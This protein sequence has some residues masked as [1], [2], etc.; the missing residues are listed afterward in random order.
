MMVCF[1]F[2]FFTENT[3]CSELENTLNSNLDQFLALLRD[4]RYD[5]YLSL[6]FL[7]LHS[8]ASLK[9]GRFLFRLK[10]AVKD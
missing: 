2:F 5:I 6:Q 4:A 7:Q 9:R 1:L 8:V 10:K 3:V